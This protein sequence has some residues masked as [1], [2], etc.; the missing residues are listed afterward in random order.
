MKQPYRDLAAVC[1]VSVLFSEPKIPQ[2]SLFQ[3]LYPRLE[4]FSALQRA[5]NSSMRYRSA[6]VSPSARIEVS[7][8]FSEPKIPQSGS[9]GDVTYPPR[10][11]FQ[12][13][14]ASR[15]FLNRRK[16]TRCGCWRRG[17]SALQRAEN[18]SITP[19]A[20]CAPH[21]MRFQCSS[22]SRKFLNASTN[23]SRY[24]VKNCFSAL[25]RAENSSIR[26]RSRDNQ[27]RSTVSV[28]FSEPKI[29]QSKCYPRVLSVGHRFSAL[30]RAENSS[31]KIDD[32]EL[33][34]PSGFSALQR[35]ENSSILENDL[36]RSD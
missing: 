17:F 35:A 33:N 12:C 5:E 32:I 15:K 34:R 10:I 9:S 23:S 20:F 27:L 22:A 29:P 13:S 25:Q 26:P 6:D 3:T 7:V 11:P 2:S 8:L 36:A 30:Q 14:S 1:L 21:Q 18:S 31:I 4:G 24:S 16:T 28:L 19:P